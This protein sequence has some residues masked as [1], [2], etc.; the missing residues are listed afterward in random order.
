MKK[1]LLSLFV[2]GLLISCSA[3][4]EKAETTTTTPS[5]ETR[6]VE[7]E[8]Q[9]SSAVA[10]YLALKDILVKSDAQGAVEAAKKLKESLK[11]EKWDAT[12]IAAANGIASFPDLKAQR[13]YFKTITD[14]MIETLQS[15]GTNQTVYIQYCPMAFNNTGASWLSDSKDILNPYFGDK[16]LKC[17]AVKGEI[18]KN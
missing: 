3:K 10:D 5:V 2:A 9:K 13:G 7:E 14:K 18:A 6:V 17:G 1:S 16:M 15:N 11:N 8:V 12:M 4:S